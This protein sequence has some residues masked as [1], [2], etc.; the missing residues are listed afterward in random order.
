MNQRVAP[1]EE[2]AG[3]LVVTKAT[4][5]LD[6][7]RMGEVME[8]AKLMGMSDV[9]VPKHL[10]NNPGACLA[11]TMQAVEWGFSPFQVAN[12]SYSVNDRLAYESQLIHAVILKRAPVKGRTK[13]EYTGEG[14][15]RVCRVWVDLKDE[16]G[17]IAEYTSPPFATIQPK[18]SPLWKT[19][20]DQQLFYFSARSL[21]RRHFPDVILGVYAK[22]EIEDSSPIGPDH[23]RDVTPA[24]GSALAARL[25]SGPKATTGFDAAFVAVETAT[26]A[27]KAKQEPAH[28]P[29]TGEIAE[30]VKAD[31][32]V[33]DFGPV[34]G[35]IVEPEADAAPAPEH[36]VAT[37]ARAKAAKG[38]NRLRLWAK[39]ITPEEYAEHVK[40][41]LPE[42]LAVAKAADEAAA[43]WDEDA[44]ASPK[45]DPTLSAM[46]K[47]WDANQ[48]K[49][50]RTAIPPEYRTAERKAEAD[51]W[52]EGWDKAKDAMSD[53]N[54][55]G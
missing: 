15:T 51:A 12:K 24:K 30:E 39:S 52:V 2:T 44:D 29:E 4:G 53:A 13:V 17:Q 31:T 37:T 10:R 11:V 33:D 9:A 40:P 27:A 25:A 46:Q 45:T 8:F 6:F 18:N 38:A 28:D 42:L 50:K 7:S 1:I 36:E 14:P 41:I 22:D 48:A 34:A 3:S 26:P 49:M 20:P 47:G 16:P 54:V 55:E 35:D 5:G 43:P 19:D 32:V 21:A 23:A